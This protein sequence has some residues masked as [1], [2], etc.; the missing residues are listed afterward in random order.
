M[1]FGMTRISSKSQASCS[2]RGPFTLLQ[3]QQWL[4]EA[5]LEQWA[6]L[7]YSTGEHSPL[8]QLDQKIPFLYA[9]FQLEDRS[10]AGPFMKE[11][12]CPSLDTH[13]ASVAQ[14][15]KN[16]L[17][18]HQ[19]PGS[20]LLVTPSAHDE[21]RTQQ[22]AQFHQHLRSLPLTLWAIQEH[23]WVFT[24][25]TLIERLLQTREMQPMHEALQWILLWKSPLPEKSTVLSGSISSSVLQQPYAEWPDPTPLP[26]F[27]NVEKPVM[28]LRQAWLHWCQ[29]LRALEVFDSSPDPLLASL[30]HDGFE[31]FEP[32]IQDPEGKDY[33]WYL[34]S[35]A[36]EAYHRTR[37]LPPPPSVLPSSSEFCWP[38]TSSDENHFSK[39]QPKH[40]IC[41]PWDLCTDRYWSRSLADLTFKH[42]HFS[43]WV[44]A[45]SHPLHPN[46]L[47]GPTVFEGWLQMGQANAL[48]LAS[49]S[50]LLEPQHPLLHQPPSFFPD[51]LFRDNIGFQVAAHALHQRQIPLSNPYTLFDVLLLKI[52]QTI[53]TPTFYKNSEDQ[54]LV[55]LLDALCAVRLQEHLHQTLPDST[56]PDSNI[57]TG[58]STLSPPLFEASIPDELPKKPRL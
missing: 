1:I 4:R 38:P 12:L 3:W 50:A 39:I 10:L 44:S 26:H 56:C 54:S 49:K 55:P 30:L 53:S 51:F 52:Q 20:S 47:K 21:T 5:S 40:P 25:L 16:R 9:L 24:P 8:I 7:L 15:L 35:Y 48:Y 31:A 18:Q 19:L 57:L 6:P 45:F 58:E 27:L 22:F 42:Q 33:L 34:P 2:T 14:S 13:F 28:K 32:F 43:T 17:S 11:L 23:D 46:K 29:S 41:S 36:L 37:G